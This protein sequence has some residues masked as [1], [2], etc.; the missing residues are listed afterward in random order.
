MKKLFLLGLLSLTAVGQSSI[1]KAPRDSTGAILYGGLGLPYVIQPTVTVTSYSVSERTLL[2]I[3]G[4]DTG[5]Q[6]RNIAIYNPD[7]SETVFVCAG[8]STGCTRDMWFAPPQT[9]FAGD[10]GYFGAGN[11]VTHIYYRVSGGAGLS[12]I[13]SYW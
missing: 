1:I 5:R 8:D 4:P 13:I 9:G 7:A 3:T 11:N 6:Y 2:S 12:P 10:F